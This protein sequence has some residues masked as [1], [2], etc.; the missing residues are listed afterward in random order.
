MQRA[1]GLDAEATCCCGHHV[2]L[3]H[4]RAASSSCRWSPGARVVLVAG[5]RPRPTARRCRAARSDHGVTVMQATPATWRDC[6]STRAGRARPR[7]RA[8]C[9][10]EA[11]PRELADALLRARRRAVWNLYGPTE[12]TIWSTVRRVERGGGAGHRSAR[13]IANTQVYVLDARVQPVPVG[14][15]RRAVHRRRRRGARLSRPPELTAE[16]FVPDP[17]GRRRARA[18]TAPA[19][20]RAGAPTARS[21]SSGRIDHQVKVRGFR[22]ELGRDRGGARAS[23]RGAGRPRRR[24]P[25]D[26]PGRQA[27]GRLRRRPRTARSLHDRASCAATCAGGCPTTWSRR[28][29]PWPACR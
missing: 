29:S 19:T 10:G 7:L 20:W 14:R 18:S 28:P 23:I 17:F 5:E 2:S 4:R 1:T 16:R 8:L 21:S 24:R 9:G 25:R 12:T 13:P 26:R 11:L 15:R 27:P 6:C 22:I 3:R